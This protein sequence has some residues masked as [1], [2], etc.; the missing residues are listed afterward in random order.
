MNIIIHDL[1][2]AKFFKCFVD[3]KS[4][5]NFYHFIL[6]RTCL[7]SFG[8]RDLENPPLKYLHLVKVI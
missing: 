1:V 4:F 3:I 2:N 7:Y 8:T 6:M 5:I